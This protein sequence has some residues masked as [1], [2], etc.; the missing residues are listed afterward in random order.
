MKISK[1]NVLL[2]WSRAQKRNRK[3]KIKVTKFKNNKPINNK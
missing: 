1:I 3:P 2:G